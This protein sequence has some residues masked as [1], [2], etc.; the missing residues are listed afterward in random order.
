MSFGENL[1]F[2]RKEKNI[3]QEQLAEKMQVSRQTVSKW[4]AGN[5]YPEIEK[6]LQLCDLFSCTMDTLLRGDASEDFA[7][8]TARYDEH[9]NQ[10]SIAI[11]AG[12]G[13]AITGAAVTVLF[14]NVPGLAGKL[15]DIFFFPFL[16]LAVAIFMVAGIQHSRFTKKNPFIRDFYTEEEKEKFENRFT[17]LMVAGVSIILTGLIINELY[18]VLPAPFGLP[19][20]DFYTFAFMLTAALGVI[21]LVHTGLQKSKYNI[22]EYNKNH[23]PRYADCLRPEEQALLDNKRLPSLAGKWC[24]CIMIIAAAIYLL[25]SFLWSAWSVSWVIFPVAGLLCGIAVI[26]VGDKRR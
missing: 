2:Y 24:G 8:D 9:M 26:I 25:W 11:A 1:Q 12:T 10:Y 17:V 18:Q 19:G 3:T 7:Q 22:E 16:I 23:D 13:L 5:S 15:G 6:I 21:I 14:D 20:E 4:E